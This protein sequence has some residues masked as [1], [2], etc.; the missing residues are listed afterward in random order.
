MHV[1]R[2]PADLLPSL[3]C[4]FMAALFSTIRFNR[5][6]GTDAAAAIGM[7]ACGG[8]IWVP[9]L[10]SA[11]LGEDNLRKRERESG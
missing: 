8:T 11:S 3:P 5:T 1:L 4:R 6:K 9:R 7:V 10:I 2:E